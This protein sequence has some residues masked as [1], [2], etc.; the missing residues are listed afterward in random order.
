MEDIMAE[1]FNPAPVD[2]HAAKPKAAQAADKKMHN[3]LERVW[4]T[5]SLRLIR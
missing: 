5:R 2:K 4:R 3:R 1:K